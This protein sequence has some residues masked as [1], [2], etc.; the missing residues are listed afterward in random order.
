[1]Q[2]STRLILGGSQEHV[3]LTCEGLGLLGH[4]ISL[5]YG[6]IY[7]PEGS[8]LNQAK[9]G[10]YELFEISNLVRN[11]NPY[12]DW[13]AFG[14]LR[15]LICQWKP[16]VVHTNSSKAGILGRLAAAKENVPCIVHTV[17]GLPFHRYQY[18]LLNKLYVLLERIAAKKTDKILVVADRLR[19]KMLRNNIG[20]KS[21]YITIRSGINIESFLSDSTKKNNVRAKYGFSDSDVVVGTISRISSLKGHE[22]LIKAIPAVLN[23]NKNVK[24]FWIGDGWLK[25]K[26]MKKAKLLN[27]QEKIILSGLVSP[28]K[29]PDLQKAIDILV[30]PSWR[31]GLPRVVV[32]ALASSIPVIATDADGT[33]E[34]IQNH[35][36][37]WLIKV[38]DSFGLSEA[39]NE[40]IEMPEISE[41][42]TKNGFKI[43][44]DAFSIDKMIQDTLECY[45]SILDVYSK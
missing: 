7:G 2:I 37:G 42:Y 6:P 28:E 23:K 20:N 11:I 41:Q 45:D 29:I 15:K 33:R 27:V 18:K 31:E 4:Q 1:M 9:K 22:D 19:D 14:Q 35:H 5:A 16:D 36:T 21:Q 26:V 25:D 34:V 13:L 30:H 39:I 43:V 3:L 12:K 40:C 8:L 38:G 10:N 17:H 32:Q 44:V 24:F